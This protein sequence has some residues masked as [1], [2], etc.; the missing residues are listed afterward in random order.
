MNIVPFRF[1]HCADLHLESPFEG[2]HSA[3]P[4]VAQILREATFRS[5]ENI[6]NLAIQQEADFIVIAG[7]IYDGADRNL[8]AQWR[9][10][11]L[12]R[13]AGKSGIKFYISHGNHDP[14]SGWEP[15]LK[16]PENV[17]RFAENNVERV[18]VSRGNN[19]LACIYGISYHTRE[20]KENLASRFP[21][22]G[23]EPFAIGI[24]HCNVGGST[25]HDNYAPCTAND[26]MSCGM[27]Y[28]ALG[29][30]HTR[31][32]LADEPYIIYSGNTQGRSVR[33]TGEKG[34]Y[35]VNVDDQGYAD[36]EFF[37]TDVV[38]WFVEDV[39]IADIDDLD[40]LRDI[41]TGKKEELRAKADG[42]PVIVRLQLSGRGEIHSQL[43]NQESEN[44]ASLNDDE[45][46]KGEFVWV[47]SLQINT[48]PPVDIDELRQRDSFIGEFLRITESLRSD[49]RQKVLHILKEPSEHQK[50]DDCLGVLSDDELISILDDAEIDGLESLLEGEN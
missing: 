45:Q 19:T 1:I 44:L 22:K 50:I 35:V 6:I 32:I 26:L 33:E 21:K 9:F 23:E 8:R 18:F 7:D 39:S 30:I 34:C 11:E 37:A 14:L 13:K 25:D 41:L 47:E 29:H 28:W 20:V 31:K 12:L 42:R 46:Y 43:R 2:I 17:H 38:R 24:L 4:E 16:L 40:M 3:S 27:D 10:H 15:G 36:A 49:T 48:R 5:F